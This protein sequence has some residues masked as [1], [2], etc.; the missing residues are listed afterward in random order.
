MFKRLRALD[1]TIVRLS[2]CE[3][4]TL[5]WQVSLNRRSAPAL[6]VLYPTRRLLNARVSAF[7]DYLKAAF[8]QGTAD[9]LA[10]YVEG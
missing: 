7:L 2:R 3:D 9:E 4:A 8:P 6:W 10:A 1:G 5:V